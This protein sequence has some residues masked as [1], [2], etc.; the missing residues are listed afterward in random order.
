MTANDEVPA[1]PAAG[2]LL[3]EMGALRRR[4]RRTRQAYWFPL[5]VF[6]LVEAGAAPFYYQ[7]PCPGTE[8]CSGQLIRG[9]L[10]LG[11]WYLGAVELYALVASLTGL[12]L[13]VWWYRRHARRAG[14]GTGTR[15]PLVAWTATSLTLL[16]V[17]PAFFFLWVLWARST[18][19]LLAIAIA[20]L[21]LAWAERSVLLGA[22]AALHAV[23]A[24][25]GVSYDPENLLYS[26]LS[27]FGVADADLPFDYGRTVNVLLPAS[28]LLL[29]GLLALALSRRRAG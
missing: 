22:V 20:L 4:A 21:A 29:G 12:G 9:G 25:L 11:R 28:V 24:G 14:V 26:V 16:L 10:H 1:G 27:T 19:W 18:S 2:A 5:L 8:L 6:G 13:T 15:G 3:E 17:V 7:K 23:A